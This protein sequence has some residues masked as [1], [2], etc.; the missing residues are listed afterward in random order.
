[1][2][3]ILILYE[4]SN[5]DWCKRLETQL[6]V[7]QLRFPFQIQ[8][9]HSTHKDLANSAADA[10][11][12]VVLLSEPFC[13]Q[14]MLHQKDLAASL[15][16]RIAKGKPVYRLQVSTN[17]GVD[18]LETQ[19]A[20]PLNHF[21]D[22]LSEARAETALV[23]LAE[24]IAANF[25][26][27]GLLRSLHLQGLG[28]GDH[29]L[30]EAAPRFNLITGD[31]GLGKSFLLECAWWALTGTWADYPA[32]PRNGKGPA[33]MTVGW[34]GD[35]DWQPQL[36]SA[37]N[38]ETRAWPSPPQAVP[39]Y[40]LS[41]YARSDGSFCVWDPLRAR[42]TP[43]PGANRV[44]GAMTLTRDQVWHGL[45]EEVRGQTRTL[46]RGVLKG[47]L[48]WQRQEPE[49]FDAFTRILQL[50]AEDEQPL[51]PGDPLPIPGFDEEIPTLIYPY[52]AVPVVHAAASV[53][54][55][56][57]LAYMLVWTWEQHGKYVGLNEPVDHMIVLV[58][59][60]EAHLHPRWKRSVIPALLSVGQALHTNLAIQYL[61]T[62]HGPM[63]LAGLEPIFDREQ[64]RLF[65][66]GLDKEQRQAQLRQLPFRKHGRADHWFTSE[67]FGM[68]QA[69]SAEAEKAIEQAR[70]LQREKQPDP[71]AVAQTHAV[72][73]R[74][75]GEHDGFWS[76][77]AFF[78]EQHGVAL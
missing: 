35:G 66:F 11:V 34:Q 25:Q 9:V 8:N 75:L 76:R 12:V 62:T 33:A 65:T 57:G 26:P 4:Q 3:N 38:R 28:P 72:L 50:L 23:N 67:A 55:I 58:D 77:W 60:I 29:L 17:P 52:G 36:T 20:W 5:L 16:Q 37:Y 74:V 32:L 15:K 64:D 56:V 27:R 14:G 42:S 45:Y 59:E 68:N 71:E 6:G 48:H 1:M 31:N 49:T 18:W 22:Q 43:P 63:V 41:V 70:R 51:T 30:L 19:D 47:W 78:A 13:R 40:N 44:H 53:K 10:W 73:E 69:R 24:T 39:F 61:I 2:E 21:L 7:L 54:R 46:C